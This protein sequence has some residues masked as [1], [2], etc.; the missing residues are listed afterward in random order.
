MRKD[1]QSKHE[2]DVRVQQ[3]RQGWTERVVVKDIC[4]SRNRVARRV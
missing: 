3:S 1:K 4:M 2:A